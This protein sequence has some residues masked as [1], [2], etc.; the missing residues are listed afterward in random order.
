MCLYSSPAAN[1]ETELIGSREVNGA[2]VNNE[3]LSPAEYTSTQLCET[4]SLLSVSDPHKCSDFNGTEDSMSSEIPF[5]P[6]PR[7][8]FAARTSAGVEIPAG[9]M[10]EIPATVS[11]CMSTLCT[12]CNRP[13]TCTANV[14]VTAQLSANSGRKSLSP[15]KLTSFWEELDNEYDPTANGMPEL[16]PINV[17]DDVPFDGFDR[18]SAFDHLSEL[19]DAE[20]SEGKNAEGNEEF[21]A[22]SHPEPDEMVVSADKNCFAGTTC[23][24]SRHATFCSSMCSPPKSHTV[25]D[26]AVELQHNSPRKFHSRDSQRKLS[27]IA[28]DKTPLKR[29][30]FESVV[31]GDIVFNHSS[32]QKQ[33]GVVFSSD[34]GK[35]TADCRITAVVSSPEAR[36]RRR[37]FQCVDNDIEFNHASPQKQRGVIISSDAGKSTTADCQLATVLSPA[38]VRSQHPSLQ[39]IVDNDIVFN[40]TSPQKQQGIFVSSDV[41]KSATRG[42]Q[43]T[44][45]GHT[46]QKICL[47]TTE[48]CLVPSSSNTQS[49]FP[50]SLQPVVKLQRYSC[51]K[52]R[53]PAKPATP[54]CGISTLASSP[55]ANSIQPKKCLLGLENC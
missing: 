6:P 40:H 48:N 2:A 18:D 30:S 35:P 19:Y 23:V 26:K 50:A 44:T 4:I 15:P 16:F 43:I 10:A 47:F 11:T 37:S 3:I 32:P 14:T 36:G 54:D 1:E 39:C 27:N 51:R 20:F 42:R 49:D 28:S 46:R 5:T 33:C 8:P 34:T 17:D 24:V 25:F 21:E 7:I 55:K 52:R 9:T 53:S 38:E 41:D 13:S 12:G 45:A 22:D 31:D 29:P